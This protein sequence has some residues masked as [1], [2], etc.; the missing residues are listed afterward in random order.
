MAPS[1]FFESRTATAAEL[2]SPM[3][4]TSTHAL[5]ATE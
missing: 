4:A 1:G 2:S 5:F 3:T